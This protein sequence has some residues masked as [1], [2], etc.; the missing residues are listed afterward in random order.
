MF[1]RL[2][3][4]VGIVIAGLVVIGILITLIGLILGAVLP[5][6]LMRDLGSGADLLY[7]LLAPAIPAIVALLLVGAIVWAVSGRGR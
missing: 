3:A 2:F 1:G 4:R 6:Q 7:S 5:G